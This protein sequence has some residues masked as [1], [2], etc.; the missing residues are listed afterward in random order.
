MFKCIG[1]HLSNICI[2]GSK[3]VRFILNHK[4][5]S[6]NDL[7]N[8]INFPVIKKTIK[9]IAFENANK[10]SIIFVSQSSCRISVLCAH[11][12][13][14]ICHLFTLC[15]YKYRYILKK[16]QLLLVFCT[17]LSRLDSIPVGLSTDKY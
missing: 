2:S 9:L 3:Q 11:F 1:N 12:P 13:Y 8:L 10:P 15:I 6:E 17:T 16:K 7:I 5:L 14:L 4:F